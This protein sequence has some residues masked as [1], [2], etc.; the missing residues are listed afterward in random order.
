VQA[1][2]GWIDR[3]VKPIEAECATQNRKNSGASAKPKPAF[4]VQAADGNKD[5]KPGERHDRFQKRRRE[6]T[7]KANSV[8]SCSKR[9]EP[10]QHESLGERAWKWL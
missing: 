9:G 4:I 6:E 2:Q 1:L 10:G 5:A 7:A 3:R 8:A